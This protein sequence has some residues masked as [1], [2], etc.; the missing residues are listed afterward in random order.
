MT[1]YLIKPSKM[2]GGAAVHLATFSFPACPKQE[3]KIARKVAKLTRFCSYTGAPSM[4]Q[5]EPVMK[6]LTQKTREGC[7]C[8]RGLF[9]GSRGKLRESPGKIAGKIFPNREMLQIPGFRAPGKANLPGTLGP[10][11]RDLVPTFR[12]G[13]FLKSTVP[14]FSSF[15]DLITLLGPSLDTIQAL[16]WPFLSQ[17]P[18]QDPVA[19]SCRNL[20]ADIKVKD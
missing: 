17:T 19:R 13:C 20:A 8:F 5:P 9:G 3:F 16:R 2:A 15:S 7:G 10:H 14:A 11:C 6:F 12:A 4:E 18:F 1:L